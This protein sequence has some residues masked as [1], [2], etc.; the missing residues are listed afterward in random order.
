MLIT[1]VNNLNS[2]ISGIVHASGKM[3]KYQVITSI[4]SLMCIPG[5][6]IALKFGCSPEV[7]VIMIFVFS[8]LSQYTALRILKTIVEYKITDYFKVVILPF[9]YLVISTFVFP[10]IPH[11]FMEES[12]L[13]LITVCIVSVI[14]VFIGIYFL[15]LNQSEKRIVV[16][17]VRKR[18]I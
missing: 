15:A 5:A 7:A 4:V 12:L 8:M 10:L 13:R 3:K 17:F 1:Y 14:T 9:V 11:Y 16:Q 6:Y 18:T 2:P